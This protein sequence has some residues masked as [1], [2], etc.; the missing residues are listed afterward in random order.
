MSDEDSAPLGEYLGVRQEPERQNALLTT[1]QRAYLYD[2]TTVAETSRSTKRQRIRDRVR[3]GLR[4]F[5]YLRGMWADDKALVFSR[6]D[7]TETKMRVTEDV[8]SFLY[9][10]AQRDGEVDFEAALEHAIEDAALNAFEGNYW[11]EDVD[12]EIDIQRERRL[13]PET[14]K[15]RVQQ[16][17]RLSDRELGALHRFARFD[18]E[19]A[20]LLEEYN[21]RLDEAGADP[22]KSMEDV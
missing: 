6:L 20:E 21:R 17:S 13:T 14:V 18:E 16:K 15:H 11:V 5:N 1:A 8:L 12:V 3:D 9:I 7:D 4:D 2:P 22:E 10:A 19:C